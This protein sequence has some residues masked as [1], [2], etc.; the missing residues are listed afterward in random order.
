M[1][2]ALRRVRPARKQ[3][4]KLPGGE[5]SPHRENTESRAGAP[6]QWATLAPLVLAYGQ[7]LN[8]LC[9]RDLRKERV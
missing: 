3:G 6:G 5:N 7:A 8:K 2:S 4:T 9:N 1:D